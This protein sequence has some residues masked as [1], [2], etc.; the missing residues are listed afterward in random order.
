M[1]IDLLRA[2]LRT[3]PSTG[4]HLNAIQYDQSRQWKHCEC[5][6]E[7]LFEHNVKVAS[8]EAP[9]LKKSGAFLW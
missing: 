6:A 5:M 1:Q 4:R 3:F 9:P 7:T 2:H 8:S